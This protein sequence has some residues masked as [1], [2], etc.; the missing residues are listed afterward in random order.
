M[1][2]QRMI[3][4]LATL[5]RNSREVMRLEVKAIA[6]DWGVLLFLVGAFGS[7][8]LLYPFTYMH[9]V[10]RDVPVAVVDLSN[11]PTS[12]QL[13]RMLD[14]TEAVKVSRQLTGLDEA[15]RD[16]FDNKIYGIMVIPSDFEQNILRNQ[17]TS[18]LAYLDASYFM[19]YRQVLRGITLASGTMSGGIEIKRLGSKGLNAKARDPLPLNS[20][21]LYNPSGGYA[22]YVMIAIM[23]SLLQQTLLIGIGILGGTARESG[24]HH[25]LIP[26]GFEDKGV[27]AV[28]LGKGMTFFLLYAV[29]AIYIFGVVFQLFDYPQRGSLLL[30][31]FLIFSYLAAL[32]AMGFAMA[33]LFRYRET[34]I[35]VFVAVSLPS[36]LSAGFSWPVE[37]IPPVIRFFTNFIPGVPGTDAMIRISQMGASLSDV[38]GSLMILWAQVLLDSTC[39]ILVVRRILRR[40][41]EGIEL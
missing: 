21:A 18:V 27:M 10:V 38:S 25:Y 41:R 20:V 15:K 14:A 39:S 23:F 28:L 11:T 33:S 36:V 26:P 2:F 19:V 8:P 24:A 12:R 16:F 5:W 30:S 4:S 34:A 6:A 9:E 31:G 7:Y 13:V 3:T 40:Q 17:Q 29:H 35:A 22:T 1:I 37:S 32:I